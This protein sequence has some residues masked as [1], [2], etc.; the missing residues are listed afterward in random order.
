MEE[1][2]VDRI[3]SPIGT[4]LLV[5]DERHVEEKLI[6]GGGVER[7]QVRH[8]GIRQQQAI[9]RQYLAFAHDHPA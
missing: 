4:V 3:E 8:N 9:S 7:I 2:K 1:L 6:A 5:A